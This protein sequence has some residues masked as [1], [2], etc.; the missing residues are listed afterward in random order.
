MSLRQEKITELHALDLGLFDVGPGKRR[1]LCPAFVLT[2]NQGRHILF[3]TGFPPSYA[4]DERAAAAKDG[5]DG[6]GR[7]VNFTDAP[8][9]GTPQR[10][11]RV[12]L[13][14]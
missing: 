12:K 1:I 10:F 3:D 8:P 14:P 5:L 2:T 9:A 7:L 4:S 6:F 13:L 11:Y